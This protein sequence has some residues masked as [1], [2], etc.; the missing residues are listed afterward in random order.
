MLKSGVVTRA[1]LKRPT[2]W[3]GKK[4]HV[5]FLLLM[6]LARRQD[7]TPEEYDRFVEQVRMP[8]GVW[9]RTARGR[10]A[11]LD[12]IVLDLLRERFPAGS[13]LKVLDL[14]ASTGVTSVDFY[15]TLSSVF[16]V[17]FI[18]S[19]L[20]RDL[21]AVRPVRWPWVGI[22][23][24]SGQP[25]QYIMPGLVLPAQIEESRV[26]PINRLLKRL[27]RT[28]FLPR[29]RAAI[30]RSR[31]LP[32]APF[33]SVETD[34]YSLTRLPLLSKDCLDILRTNPRFRFEVGNIL[35]TLP[36]RGHVV[37]AMNI[38]TKDHFP[39]EQRARAIQNCLD[40]TLPNGLF[41][42]GWSPTPNPKTVEA[43]VYEVRESGLCRL[44]ST[45]GGSEIDRIVERVAPV[46][47]FR[48]QDVPSSK[49]G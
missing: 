9:K 32:L 21:I 29:S 27:G 33:E 47:A 41:V 42:I 13:A 19:D 2:T 18:A 25:I 16:S 34:G 45:N 8:N 4:R 37:R 22:F 17:E 35:E 11:V 1:G 15:R 6:D 46:C 39:D 24:T 26:Y 28:L 38:L 49:A 10:L 36:H 7:T 40:A 43:S 48:R 30:D 5:S 3:F 31:S 44:T 20:Y 12:A 23:D 14:A